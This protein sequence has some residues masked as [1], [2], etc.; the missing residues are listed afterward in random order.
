MTPAKNDLF[1]FW[2]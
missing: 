2:M 1:M